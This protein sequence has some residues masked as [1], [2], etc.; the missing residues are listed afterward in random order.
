MEGVRTD[1]GSVVDAYLA[2]KEDNELA[3]WRLGHEPFLAMLGSVEGK[4]ILDFGCGPANFSSLLS[5][6]GARVIGVDANL[7][8][9]EAA[10]HHD[11]KG[12]Y[13]HYRGLLA[14]LLVGE[15]IDIVI[16]TFSFCVVPDRELRY[17]LRD[18]RQLLGQNKL[19]TKRLMILEPNQQKAHGIDYGQLHYHLKEGV[20]SGDYVHV[21]LGRG[22]NAVELYDDIYR[23]HADYQQLLEEAGFAIDLMVE[24]VPELSW[25][26][27]WDL[28]RTHPPFL[29]IS[30]T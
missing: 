18:M 15:T 30:A 23:T 17:I 2:Y 11:S 14:D 3:E 1:Y 10:R 9:I 25:G 7:G 22:E 13:H 8:T 28:E 24:P 19:R 27:E 6:R 4:R 26:P 21:T 29:I 12:Q 16:A 20:K 5:E